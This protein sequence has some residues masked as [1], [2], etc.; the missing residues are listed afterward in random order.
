MP[1]IQTQSH[2]SIK[3][4]V[5]GGG[6]ASR[7]FKARPASFSVASWDVVVVLHKNQAEWRRSVVRRAVSLMSMLCRALC[8]SV[9]W[10]TGSGRG[11]VSTESRARGRRQSEHE[12]QWLC[13]VAPGDIRSEAF[14][15]RLTSAC[16]LVGSVIRH[17]RV[18][19][20]PTPTGQSRSCWMFLAR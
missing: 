4:E 20:T 16:Q 2:G 3:A 14:T 18:T 13:D 6:S 12:P 10:E 15:E 7:L 5:S 8:L 11:Q 9:H 1:Q 19:Q 17:S